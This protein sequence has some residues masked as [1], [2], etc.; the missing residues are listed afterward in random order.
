MSNDNFIK[1]GKITKH[2]GIKGHSKLFYFGDIENFKYKEVFLKNKGELLSYFIE[3]RKIH[4]NFL[5]LKIKGINSID[6]VNNI[7]KGKDVYIK[8]SQL[9]PLE[10]G[11]YYW[12]ELLGLEV[13]DIEENYIGK[14]TDI[15]ETGSNDVFQ[16]TQGTKEILIPYIEQVV[17]KVD[18][19]SNKMI[20]QLLEE[21]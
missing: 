19:A 5:I 3:E 2:L 20:V 11:E 8:K 12:H 17:K 7:L 18:L 6:D 16:V 13:F 1:I 10:K 21:V 4:K 14:V 15:I 9:P